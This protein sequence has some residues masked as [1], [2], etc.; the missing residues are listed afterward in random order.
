MIS[1]H[2][3]NTIVLACDLE[4]KVTIKGEKHVLINYLKITLS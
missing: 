2:S 4:L 3:L 1:V